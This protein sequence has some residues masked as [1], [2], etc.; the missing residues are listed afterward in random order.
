[1]LLHDYLQLRYKKKEINSEGLRRK[2]FDSITIKD[3]ERCFKIFIKSSRPLDERLAMFKDLNIKCP[4]VNSFVDFVL[5]SKRG[6]T[7]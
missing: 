7:R 1:M 6:I 3:L 4:H 5:E 2:K